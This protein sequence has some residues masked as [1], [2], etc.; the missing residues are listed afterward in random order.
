MMTR[1]SAHAGLLCLSGLLLPLAFVYLE[2]HEL[3]FVASV[4][5]AA[6]WLGVVAEA[7]IDSGMPRPWLLLSGPLVLLWPVYLV[8]SLTGCWVGIGCE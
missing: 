6:C 8:V 5:I 2:A 7:W 3:A 4:I 1:L